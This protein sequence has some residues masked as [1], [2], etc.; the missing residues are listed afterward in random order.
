VEEIIGVALSDDAVS[1]DFAALEI[2]DTYRAN[3]LLADEAGM[4]DGLASADKDPAKSLHLQEVPT[5]APGPGEALVAVIAS[6]INC[7]TVW[8]A[9]FEPLPTFTF[10][11][12]YGKTGPMGARHDL[13]YHVVGSD[14]AGVVLRTG[15]GVSRWKPG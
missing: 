8:S 3:V 4:F 14:S 2:P 6:A 5:P 15:P 10:L 1:Q 9:I 13:L 12:G 11:R 7:N